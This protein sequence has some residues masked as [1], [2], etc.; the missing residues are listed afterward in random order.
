[1][2]RLRGHLPGGVSSRVNSLAKRVD[3]LGDLRATLSDCAADLTRRFNHS[4]S[5]FTLS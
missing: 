4:N 1:M 5:F 2:I 3:G